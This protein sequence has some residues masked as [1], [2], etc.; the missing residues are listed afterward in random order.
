[1]DDALASDERRNLWAP[2]R[3]E[4]I[5][6]LPIASDDDCFLCRCRDETDDDANLVVWRG[7]HTIAVLNR[8]PYTGG[9]CLVAPYEHVPDL[10]D[11]PTETLTEMMEMLRDLQRTLSEALHPNGFNV[12]INLG[13]CAGAGL[14]GH[15]HA[16]IVPRWEGDTNFMPVFGKVH[17]VPEFLETIL[18]NIRQASDT[19]GLP[20]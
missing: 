18:K 12:G 20:Y 2:W 14:P 16:H 10:T 1:M 4:Y 3:M 6:Q 19:L 5:R 15:I 13:R 8:F 9:H 11:L 17:V 7:K